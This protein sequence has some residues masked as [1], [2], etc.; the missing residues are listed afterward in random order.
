MTDSRIPDLSPFASPPRQ[1]LDYRTIEVGQSPVDA[2]GQAVVYEAAVPGDAPPDRVALKEPS[3]DHGTVT[4]DVVDAFLDEASTWA[5]LDR[6]ERETPRWA[7]SEHVVGIVDT[8]TKLPWIAM[9]YMDGGDL[10]DR[11]DGTDGLPLEEA[12][13]IGE[14]VC[15]AI[16][17]AHNYGVAH[18]D[19]KPANVLFRETEPGSWDVPKLA[20]WGLARS[21][22]EQNDTVDGLSVRYA[23]PEQFEPEEFGEPDMLT[24]VYQTGALVYAL[25]TGRPPFVGTQ[26]SVMYDVVSDDSPSPPSSHRDDVPPAVDALVSIALET[27]KRDRYDAI[28]IFRQA[29]TAARTGQALPPSVADRVPDDSDGVE[30][31]DT[32]DDG[33]Q[34]FRELVRETR[35][36]GESDVGSTNENENG[37]TDATERTFRERVG[38]IRAERAEDADVDVEIDT[39]DDEDEEDDEDMSFRERVEEIRAERAEESGEGVEIDTSDDED[40]EDDEDLSF[41]ERVEEIRAERAEE[42]DEDVERDTPDGEDHED[43][44][45]RERVGDVRERRAAENSDDET[46]QRDGDV[47]SSEFD[48]DAFPE[49][50]TR[51]LAA[52]IRAV[53]DGDPDRSLVEA[54]EDI[55]DRSLAAAVA[56]LSQS[57]DH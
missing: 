20:D 1:E 5:M 9:E 14:C 13:W 7:G 19:I 15:R 43:K 45:F 16:D 51:D 40:E 33:E 55:D 11:L 41:R 4:G 46:G 52:A 35:D 27:S 26:M 17:L 36:E 57:A 6:H 8:G 48:P 3:D 37:E 30:S 22:S 10:A 25:L 38:E 28:Q 18:L 34:S 31:H 21:L 49:A 47:T 39:S 56:L 54:V 50:R 29:L 32:T 2:G 12:L 42:A 23:A 24:D 53:E 44:P